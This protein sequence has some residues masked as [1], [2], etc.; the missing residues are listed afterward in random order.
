MTEKLFYRDSHLKEFTA[1]VLSCEQEKEQFK[2]VL[3]RTAFFPEGG[4]QYGDIGWLNGIEVTDTQENGD[5]VYHYMKAPL[6]VGC[7][8]K[9]KLNWEVQ[10]VADPDA[11]AYGRAYSISGLV[12]GR[13]RI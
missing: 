13:F 1:Q 2:V 9:G 4:G 12:H 7:E 10:P 5:V 11:A 3:D 8:V 6:E